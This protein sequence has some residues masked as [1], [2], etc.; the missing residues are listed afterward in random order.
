MCFLTHQL[1]RSVRECVECK[2]WTS[3]GS[4]MESHTVC[5]CERAALI[6][7]PMEGCDRPKSLLLR[8]CISPLPECLSVVIAFISGFME[9]LHRVGDVMR[10]KPQT[11]SLHDLI[12]SV[13]L[14]R[15]HSA[16]G[17][18]FSCSLFVSPPFLFCLRNS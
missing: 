11:S 8:Y 6:T 3:S 7:L 17:E 14:T 5:G 12:C 4:E 15:C 10:L 1:A 13:S 9:L 16:F 2:V 18:Y